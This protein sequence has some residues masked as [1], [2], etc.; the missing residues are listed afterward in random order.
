MEK[1][2]RDKRPLGT[3]LMVWQEE[4]SM[5]IHLYS[6]S[7]SGIPLAYI[8]QRELKKKKSPQKHRERQQKALSARL[9]KLDNSAKHL[10]NV[11]INTIE[12][13]QS[14]FWLLSGLAHDTMNSFIPSTFPT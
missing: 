3:D 12:E 2:G 5:C 8:D 14:Q 7:A 11:Y 4:R 6:S 1:S 10:W 13:D 9:I